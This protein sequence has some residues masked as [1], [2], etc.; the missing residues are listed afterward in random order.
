MSLKLWLP[1]LGL[2]LVALACGPAAT[3]TGGS[4]SGT[5][6]PKSGGVLNAPE[7]DDPYDFDMSYT[8]SS[9]ANPFFIKM[10]YSS[11]LKLKTGPGIAYSEVIVEPHLAERW[12][13]SPDAK[14][15]TFY[16]RKGVKFANLPPVNGR[17]L[18]S[19]DVK[20]SYEYLSRTGALKDAKLPN[21]QFA[22][23]FE[24]LDSIQAP[25]PY[26][27]VVKFKE[28]FA[29]FL[30]YAATS[31]NVIMP[32]E[33]YD[34][35]GHFK[36]RIV[37][38]GPFQLDLQASQRGSRWVMKKNPD[39]FETG[40]PFLDGL[41]A[42]VIKEQTIRQAAFFAKQTDYYG[43]SADPRVWDEVRRT[44]PNAV[45]YEYTNAAQSL[46]LNFKRPPFDNMKVREAVANAVDRDEIIKIAAGGRGEW[47]LMFSNVF[48]DLFTQEEIK[49]ILPYDPEKAKRLLTE[50]GYPNGF[51]V[52]MIFDSEG[53]E[54]AKQFAQLIQ[55]QL[56][57]VGINIVFETLSGA[58][59]T[60]RRRNR[61]MNM[62]ILGEAGRADLDSSLHLAI[63][64]NGSFNYL[65]VDDPKINEL[66][67]AQR[68]ETNPAKRRELLRELLRYANGN[69]VVHGVFRANSNIFRQAYVKDMYH[70]ADNRGV[71]I[72]WN[73]WLDK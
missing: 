16:L 29:P 35:D 62:M 5:G 10:A 65:N 30:S 41:N 25:D 67:A 68:R 9:V 58:D 15:Y 22:F 43:A 6:Q 69:F 37:G 13:V 27:V 21:S 71:G 20:W 40:R 45:E 57:K 24:G 14:T 33:I 3:Q 36:E 48:S 63:H 46:Y 55:A 51:T 17:E 66:L 60:I 50:A 23:L 8:G 28:S 39:Y 26:T 52:Q 44:L 7:T 49:K 4:P 64:P 72:L 1:I 38:S 18:T 53:S 12:E 70:H 32:H 56:K 59:Y 42:F 47:A 19:A 73:T 54:S 61:D 31:D 11:L 34:Q 2:A